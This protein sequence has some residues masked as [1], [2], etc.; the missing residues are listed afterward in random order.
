MKY[1]DDVAWS[2]LGEVNLI[3]YSTGPTNPNFW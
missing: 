3:F 2:I 1:K